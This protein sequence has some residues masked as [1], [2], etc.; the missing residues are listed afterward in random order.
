[1]RKITSIVLTLI[2]AATL[3]TY[4][5]LA[6]GITA[7]EQAACSLV[8][9]QRA[10]LGLQ[11]LTV[12]STLSDK[13]RIKAQDMAENHY[14]SHNSPTYGS[15]FTMMRQLGITYRSAGENIAMGY[16]T[17]EAVV[18]GWMASPSHRANILLDNY[19]HIGVGRSGDY[20]TQWFTR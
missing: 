11:T 18:A 5:A 3:M 12:S 2:L 14:F 4:P 20:W 9:D 7:K 6:A 17:A 8:N 13:A 19:T 16:D 10:A 15:P 1:M